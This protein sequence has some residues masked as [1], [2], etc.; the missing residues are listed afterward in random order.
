MLYNTPLSQLIL[1]HRNYWYK[2]KGLKDKVP[3]LNVCV[4]NVHPRNQTQIPTDHD[5]VIDRKND[6]TFSDRS[7]K[8]EEMLL[9]VSDYIELVRNLIRVAKEAGA[10]DKDI[11]S[12]LNQTTKYHGMNLRP[13]LYKEIVEGRFDINQIVRIERKNDENTISDKTFDFSSG[14]ITQLIKDGF[15]DTIDLI[16]SILRS[17]VS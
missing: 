4:I 9:L 16:N 2:I 12:L 10:K 6:I 5:G 1:L 8:D 3:T 13:R 7:H 14:T 17:R 11:S 15:E